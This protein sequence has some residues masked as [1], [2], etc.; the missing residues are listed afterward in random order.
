MGCPISDQLELIFPPPPVGIHPSLS[1]GCG[2]SSSS[3]ALIN[4]NCYHRLHPWRQIGCSSCL[5]QWASAPGDYA[6]QRLCRGRARIMHI[7]ITPLPAPSIQSVSWL[8]KLSSKRWVC[9]W[10][11][12]NLYFAVITHPADGVR[13]GLWIPGGKNSGLNPLTATAIP[14]SSR[15]PCSLWKMKQ[16]FTPCLLSP[17]STG[18]KWKDEGCTFYLGG[19]YLKKLSHFHNGFPNIRMPKRGVT[20]YYESKTRARSVAKYLLSISF[21]CL[22]KILT[23][24]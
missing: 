23:K 9:L 13:E 1:P 11:S 17:S 21:L 19:T 8:I 20:V 15:C 5:L 10:A 12:W 6:H 16:L 22:D 4:C 14:P 7:F 18:R 2:S 24:H 3:V